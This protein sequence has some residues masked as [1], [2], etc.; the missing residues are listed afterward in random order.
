MLASRQRIIARTDCMEEAGF[1]G[2]VP[3][4]TPLVLTT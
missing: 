3:T 4:R 1:S 2:Y